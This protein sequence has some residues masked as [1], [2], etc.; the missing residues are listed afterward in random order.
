MRKTTVVLA[1]LAGLMAGLALSSLPA[2]TG[3]SGVAGVAGAPA[4]VSAAGGPSDTTE[5]AVAAAGGP[6]GTAVSADAAAGGPSATEDAAE[7][8][9]GGPSDTEDEEDAEDAI[10]LD[11][12]AEES[13]EKRKLA[14]AR[15]YRE[16]ALAAR[17]EALGPDHPK[18]IKSMNELGSVLYK[19]GKYRAASDMFYR[20]YAAMEGELTPGEPVKKLD[21]PNASDSIL[22]ELLT[23]PDDDLEALV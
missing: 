13:I 20:A 3:P 18:T 5:A 4:A 11:R 17:Q 23:L 7:A 8:G 15:R 6:S 1:A 2:A 10:R 22:D 9:A 16:Q 14:S 21:L 19:L 12:L